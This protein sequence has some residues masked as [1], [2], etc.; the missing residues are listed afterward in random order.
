MEWY[1][2]M[3]NQPR[4]VGVLWL[5][6]SCY[7]VF[8][9]EIYFGLT[10]LP[11]LIYG[12]FN[13]IQHRHIQD[14]TLS[15]SPMKKSFCRIRQIKCH[16]THWSCA[17]SSNCNL[18]TSKEDFFFWIENK[19]LSTRL[20]DSLTQVQSQELLTNKYPILVIIASTYLK[21][22]IWFRASVKCMKKFPLNYMFF[23]LTTLKFN[24]HPVWIT[25]KKFNIIF[26]PFQCFNLVPQALI[27]WQ[28]FIPRR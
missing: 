28:S 1:G 2:I 21:T 15:Y 6:Y 12:R 24:T 9:I 19:D 25:I 16:H 4:C 18:E 13:F 17:F 27:S 8:A 7:S 23:Q 20:T 22:L 10:D 11:E 3:L 26:H 14:S 5:L